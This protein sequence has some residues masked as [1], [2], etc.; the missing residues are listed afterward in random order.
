MNLG[1]PLL[2][3]RGLEV[4]F[5]GFRAIDGVDL[6]IGESELRFLIGPNGAGKTTI[7]DVITG[8]T[9]PTRGSVRFGGTELVGRREHEIVRCGVGRTFQTATVFEELTVIENLDLAAN[10]RAPLRTW[11]RVRRGVSEPVRAVL[12]I[13]HLQDLAEA[14]AGSLSHGQR[15]WLEIGM[16]V[17]Q[18][19]RLLLLD[20][21]VA[22]MSAEERELTGTLLVELAQRHTVV[23][24]EHDM[25]FLRRFAR[26]VTVLHEGRIL[27][28]GSVEQVQA[29]PRVQEVYLGR[30][31]TEAA[32]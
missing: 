28:E 27:V 1:A 3:I 12:A 30:T 20:E 6:T 15:Q 18:Q 4:V 22:G 31:R 26:S 2:E 23:V 8:L 5:D 19:P 29:D 7:I 16:L 32:S 14:P 9:K 25:A 10:F 21:P 17:A 24:I 11:F 13:T